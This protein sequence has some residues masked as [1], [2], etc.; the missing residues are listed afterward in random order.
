MWLEIIRDSF[1]TSTALVFLSKTL[2][3]K[4][5]PIDSNDRALKFPLVH[6]GACFFS[7]RI[8][9]VSHD[10]MLPPLVPLLKENAAAVV[11]RR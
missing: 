8:S 5:E 1:L 7:H 3:D 4:N 11:R 10:Y 6:K 2:F 9:K